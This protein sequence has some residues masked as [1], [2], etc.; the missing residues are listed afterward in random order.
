MKPEEI[1]ILIMRAPGTNCD[2]ETVR[3]FEDLGAEVNLIHTQKVFKEKNLDEYN[4][5]V[6]P[7]GFQLWRLCA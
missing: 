4:I 7:G 1:R 3:A 5:L 2:L 6:F